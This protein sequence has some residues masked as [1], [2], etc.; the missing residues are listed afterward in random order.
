MEL[1]HAVGRALGVSPTV[2][3][4]PARSEVLHAFAAHDR[5]RSVFGDMVLDVPLDEGLA[6][7]AAWARTAGVRPKTRF[8]NIEIPHGL[9]SLW[10]EP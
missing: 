2:R 10:T 5:V 4:L 6:R 8:S 9:P 3:C 7:M 1:A